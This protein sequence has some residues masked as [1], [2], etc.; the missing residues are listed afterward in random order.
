VVKLG[1]VLVRGGTGFIGSNLITD[2]VGDNK[3]FILDNLNTGNVI[4]ID[5][6]MDKV[7]LQVLDTEDVF[8]VDFA[9][10]SSG[11]GFSCDGGN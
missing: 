9:P 4:N 5:P 8:W 3:I 10:S 7:R 11:F 1:D 2:L 6:F